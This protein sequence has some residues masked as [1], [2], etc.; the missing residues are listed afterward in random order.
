MLRGLATDQGGPGLAT[1]R[2]HPADE[3]GHV[4]R[5]ELADRDVVEE[6][7]RLGAAAHDVVGA[8]RDEVDADRVEPP[9]GGGDDGLRPHAVGRG[10]QQGFA[11]ARRD[12]ERPAESAQAPDGLRTAGRV[13][14]RA[15]E[16]DRPLTGIDV[17]TGTL[18]RRPRIR[19]GP[20]RRRLLR[21]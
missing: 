5:I 9:D 19:H 21:G 17:D 2:R 14:V 20:P 6:R 1:A 16:L 11:V 8:H 13:D 7:E 15:H 10:D 18:V 3:L 4:D 12:R